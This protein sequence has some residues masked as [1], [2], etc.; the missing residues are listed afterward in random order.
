MKTRECLTLAAV[1]IGGLGIS[2][3]AGWAADTKKNPPPPPPPPHVAPPPAP[4]PQQ[5]AP[6][7]ALAPAQQAQQMRPPAMAAG[8]PNPA[9]Q[10][11]PAGVNQAMQQRQGA[12]NQ[13][14]QRQGNQAAQHPG[15]AN[16]AM[17]QHPAGGNQAM[18]GRPGAHSGQQAG[19]QAQHPSEQQNRTP[20]AAVHPDR[21]RPGEQNRQPE[22]GRPGQAARGGNMPIEHG[23]AA[24]V[25]LH[26]GQPLNQ[27]HFNEHVRD[28][29]REHEVARVHEHDFHTRDVRRFNVTER[30]HWR[31]GRW[32]NDWHSGRFGWWYQVDDVWY[33]YPAPVFPYP[34]EVAPIVVEDAVGP[35]VEAQQ[36]VAAA[37]VVVIAPLPAWPKTAFHC[38]N[39][40]GFFPLVEECNVEWVAIGGH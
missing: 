11:H 7:R 37:A 14:M 22:A 13:M 3:S 29:P 17:Q 10:Q 5:Q 2:A 24:T 39:P 1:V 27:Q 19:Q 4:R 32:H 26:P 34:L 28:I 21:P 40:E 23:P 38:S 33:A 8:R 12:G 31:T 36:P 15:A 20:V 35:I 30:E 25:G 6:M 16:Q 18:Q 9:M